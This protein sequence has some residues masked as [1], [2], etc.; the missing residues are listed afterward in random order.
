MSKLTANWDRAVK[1]STVEVAYQCKGI[2]EGTQLSWGFPEA[3]TTI[4][5]F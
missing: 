1:A 2:T 4:A 5:Y 3:N